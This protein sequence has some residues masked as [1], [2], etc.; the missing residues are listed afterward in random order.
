[1]M[2]AAA[3]D[4]AA[5]AGGA[6]LEIERDAFDASFDREP[7]YIGH[8][9]Q[10][11]PLFEL[12]AMAALSRRLESNFV[13]GA[14][15]EGKAPSPNPAD[16]NIMEVAERPTWVLLRQ[17]QTDPVYGALVDELLDQIRPFSEPLNPGMHQRE[18]FLFISSRAQVTGFHFDPE[19]NFLLQVRGRKTVHM[20]NPGDR[21]VIPADAI[22]AYYARRR[23]NRD[24]PFRDAFL[25][26]ARELPLDIGQGL[27]FPLHAPHLV[28]TESD[29]S[30]SL[31]I[32]FRTRDSKV[33]EAVHA[34]NGR[35]RR[36][37]IRPPWP[38]TSRLWDTT[39]Q[40]GYRASFLGSSV[41]KRVRK[42]RRYVVGA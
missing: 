4:R 5:D 26:R 10:G 40:L 39:A 37:G 20:W 12:P 9:L 16:R 8:N 24:Q 30:V 35:L 31:S 36:F 27:H 1:M 19:Y 42:L 32:T 29:V 22:D 33:R 2:A 14:Y 18:A 13:E 25:P 23:N 34:M 21:E 41:E 3:L 15:G 28:R 7:F 17:I 38:R 6:I 11:H